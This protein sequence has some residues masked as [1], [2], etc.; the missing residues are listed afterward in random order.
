M[1]PIHTASSHAFSSV[2]GSNSLTYSP[3]AKLAHANHIDCLITNRARGNEGLQ[4]EPICPSGLYM[5]V[6]LNTRSTTE[7][8]NQVG[9]CDSQGN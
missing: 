1:S 3:P 6:R 4:E 9:K 7:Q 5:D 2:L 8:W